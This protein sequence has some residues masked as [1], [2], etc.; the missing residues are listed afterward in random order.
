MALDTK[1]P[2]GYRKAYNGEH[3]SSPSLG[4]VVYESG[5]FFVKKA[6]H[7]WEVYQNGVTAAGRVAIYGHELFARAC[8]DA[9]RRAAALRPTTYNFEHEAQRIVDAI[10]PTR[11]ANMTVICALREA[12]EAGR[13]SR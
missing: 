8:E 2:K 10:V 12:F 3:R 11:G 13:R 4:Q 1:T 6:A 5:D 7:G 9:D